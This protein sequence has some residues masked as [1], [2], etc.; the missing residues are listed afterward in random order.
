MAATCKDFREGGVE[1]NLSKGDT[2]SKTPQFKWF[3][4]AGPNANGF[5]PP[6]SST[7]DYGFEV[8]GHDGGTQKK[9]FTTAQLSSSGVLHGIITPTTYSSS[10]SIGGETY[11]SAYT[12]H[13]HG[14]DRHGHL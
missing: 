4:V 1:L 7:S 2:K 9:L 11:S 10:F 14:S 3:Q 6:S 12:D 13:L 8:Y 5:T